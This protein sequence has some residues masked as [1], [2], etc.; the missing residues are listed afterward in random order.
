MRITVSGPPGSGT[1]SLSKHLSDKFS[2]K[3]ISAGEV[4]RSLAAERGMN[5]IEFGNLCESDPSVDKLID[6]KQK[7]IGEAEDNIIIEGRLAGHMISNADLRIWIAASPECRTR[8]IAD[9]EDVDFEASKRETIVREK[10]EAERYMKYYRIDINNL[11]VYDLVIN[12]EKWGVEELASVVF[13]AIEKIK[14]N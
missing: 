11:S 5:L 3:L 2:F 12:S 8:R 1:T 9:R 4:F 6:E 13:T 10:S 14:I 7:E